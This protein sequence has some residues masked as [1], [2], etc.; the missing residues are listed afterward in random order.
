M[1][2]DIF[3]VN[4]WAVLVSGVVYFVVGALWYSVFAEAWMKG[5]G[6]SR[7]ELQPKTSNYVVSLVCEVLLMYFLAVALNARRR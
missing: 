4:I 3:Q 1:A 7:E 2:F 6:K 5:I